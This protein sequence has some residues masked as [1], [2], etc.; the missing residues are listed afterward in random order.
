MFWQVG[1]SSRG[2]WQ[3]PTGPT[4]FGYYKFSLVDKERQRIKKKNAKK[5][6]ILL[7]QKEIRRLS[8][9]LA[10]K[11]KILSSLERGLRAGDL[12]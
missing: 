4:I 6:R 3:P 1:P 12:S 7:L 11:R 10:A 8:K 9:I 5:R 2:Y